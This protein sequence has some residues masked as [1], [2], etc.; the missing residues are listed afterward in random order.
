MVSRKWLRIWSWGGWICTSSP[1]LTGREI[2]CIFQKLS[3]ISEPEDKEKISNIYLSFAQTFNILV[4][5]NFYIHFY[6]FKKHVVSA[7]VCWLLSFCHFLRFCSQGGLLH[8]T[9]CLIISVSFFLHNKI[10]KD[11]FLQ[12]RTFAKEVNDFSLIGSLLEFSEIVQCLDASRVGNKW[13]GSAVKNLPTN[14]GDPGSSPGEKDS[15]EKETAIHSYTLACEIP[16]TEEPS[17][18]QSMGSQ[19]SDTQLS[20]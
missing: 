14:A 1:H 4:I 15:M 2:T 7:C 11:S 18:L 5:I 10:A 12:N 6:F 19:R 8:F 13:C 3:A 16:W 9:L 17:R 20:D